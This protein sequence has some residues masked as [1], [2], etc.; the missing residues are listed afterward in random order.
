MKVKYYLTCYISKKLVKSMNLNANDVVKT[1]SQYIDG[2][3]GGQPFFANASGTKLDGIPKLWEA[4]K[5]L[6]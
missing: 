1:L 3:G 5:K 4:A 6:F 2:S